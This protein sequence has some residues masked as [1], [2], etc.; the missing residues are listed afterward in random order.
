MTTH[1]A[2]EFD[3]EATMRDGA[4]LR[5]DVYRPAPAGGPWP[6][7]LARTPYGKQDPATLAR[8]DPLAAVRRGYLVVVQDTRGRHRSQGD[9]Q[10]LLH[11]SDDGYD[12]V[13]WAARLP[14]ANGRVGMFGPSYLGHTQW[15]ALTARPPELLAAVP[16]FT[17]S[18][19]RDGLL[20]RGGAHEL[21]LITQWTLGLGFDVLNRRGPA[22]L[23]H[24]APPA[25]AR[26]AGAAGSA[27]V[28]AGPAAPVRRAASP[29][30]PGTPPR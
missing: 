26:R 17:W 6:V 19:P 22:Q 13:R 16:E 2:I 14:G 24:L 12:T 1:A 30:P 7:L 23:R 27:E 10:P 9:W 5:A 11:E 20:A 15:A 25:R 8:L 4:V 28:T 21:G 18:D 29:W 3:A